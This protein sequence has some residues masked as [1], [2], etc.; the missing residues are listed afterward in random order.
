MVYLSGANAIDA[1]T[2]REWA[3]RVASDFKIRLDL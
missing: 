3:G 1:A 2:V